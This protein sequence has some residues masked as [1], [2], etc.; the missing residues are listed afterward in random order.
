MPQEVICTLEFVVNS[1][2]LHHRIRSVPTLAF[3]WNGEDPVSMGTMPLAVTP[4]SALNG[5]TAILP[6]DF[7]DL[8]L[9]ARGH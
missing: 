4:L 5:G 7:H 2:L 9:I 6:Q 3:F 1:S 8:R